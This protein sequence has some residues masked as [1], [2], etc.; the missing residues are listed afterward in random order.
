VPLSVRGQRV[1]EV[2]EEKAREQAPSG[3]C[4]IA[5]HDTQLVQHIYGAIQEYAGFE[6]GEWLM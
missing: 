2:L 3:T 1:L 5:V 4:R 6:R